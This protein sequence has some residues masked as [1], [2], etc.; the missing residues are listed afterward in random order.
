MLR[1]EIRFLVMD[2]SEEKQQTVY[3]NDQT[4]IE[5]PVIGPRPPYYTNVRIEKEYPLI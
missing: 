2:E 5:Q 3:A 4:R 1:P